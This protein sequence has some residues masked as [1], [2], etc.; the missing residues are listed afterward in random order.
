MIKAGIIGGA[1]YV[2]RELI[3]LLARHPEVNLVAATSNSQEG[4]SVGQ[5]LGDS[6]VAESLVFKK[7]LDEQVD[8][9]FLCGGHGQSAVYLSENEVKQETVVIDLSTDFRTDASWIYGLPEVNAANYGNRIANPGCF[10]T[11]IQ[12]ALLPALKLIKGAVHVNAVT[13]STGAGQA[14]SDTGHFSWRQDNLSTYKVFDH[15][16]LKEILHTFSQQGNPVGELNFIP[17]R[18]PFTRGIFATVYFDCQLSQEDA[19]ELYSDYYSE[20]PFT[21]VQKEA[22]DLKQ[23]V[24]TNFC[25][26]NPQIVNGKLVVTAAIDNLLKGAAGQAVQNMNIRFGLDQVAGL[27]LKPAFF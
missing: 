18:G 21:K 8:V 26:L 27:R 6:A 12:L 10:A 16:H 17:L 5:F 4:K 25:V 23:A 20:A 3:A 2:A 22:V 1:G 24:N 15:Q 7:K 14:L 19:F 11:A 9:L 13:G